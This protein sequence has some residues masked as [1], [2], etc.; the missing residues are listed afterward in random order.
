MFVKVAHVYNLSKQA[1]QTTF[2]RNIL[3]WT[4]VSFGVVFPDRSCGRAIERKSTGQ[5]VRW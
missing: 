3:A 1:T 5:E 4:L 2:Y